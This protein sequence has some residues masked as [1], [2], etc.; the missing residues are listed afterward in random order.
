MG[1]QLCCNC[2]SNDKTK[3]VPDESSL[4]EILYIFYSI[5]LN[6]LQN[7][8]D[9]LKSLSNS[10]FPE[11]HDESFQRASQLK[12]TSSLRQSNFKS[13]YIIS[14]TTFSI[15]LIKPTKASFT[16]QFLVIR[17]QL[18]SKNCLQY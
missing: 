4:Y 12:I 10:S 7:Q 5:S 1:L 8:S 6:E 17:Y 16:N 3:Q 9:K 15:L 2:T 11:I 14:K 18:Q 13:V